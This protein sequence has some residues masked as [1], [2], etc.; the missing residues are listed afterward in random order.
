MDL[1]V[2]SGTGSAVKRRRMLPF[3]DDPM[4]TS[5]F[6]SAQ[7]RE[8]AYDE[9]LP[10]GS[11][12][13]EGFSEDAS[14]SSLKAAYDDFVND[15]PTLPDDLDCLDL[16]LYATKLYADCIKDPETHPLPDDSSFGSPEVQM[17]VSEYLNLS[18]ETET[19]E[20]MRPLTRSS[21]NVIFK[22]R[23][24]FAWLVPKLT[25]SFIYPFGLVKPCGVDGD[26]TLKDINQKIRIP[27][28]KP[29]EDKAEPP[30]IQ[31]SAFSGKPVV[32][33]IKFH[34]GGKGSI[35][36]MRTRG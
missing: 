9:L 5:F 21:G 20:V 16:Y 17:D 7:A 11:H 4:E 6:S 3:D 28:A 19:M 1:E 15:P 25:S 29:K 35:T 33:K 14:A 23:K 36:I 18:P 30:V 32:G 13:I 31:T 10:E 22:G 34:T 12:L 27:A 8:E 24:S 2:Q 26:M